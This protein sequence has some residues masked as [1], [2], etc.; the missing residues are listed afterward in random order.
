MP[1]DDEPVRNAM[2]ALVGNPAVVATWRTDSHPI[3]EA[4]SEEV[5]ATVV[6]DDPRPNAVDVR[7][8]NRHAGALA[9]L[10]AVPV[11][12]IRLIVS[13]RGSCLHDKQTREGHA[14]CKQDC[15]NT[16]THVV[17]FFLLENL[18]D[19]EALGAQ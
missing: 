17:C 18:W 2:L 5:L 9:M 19:V 16:L 8:G 12:L 14:Q 4:V 7:V 6:T 15:N 10:R 13:R 1:A 11:R 3:L